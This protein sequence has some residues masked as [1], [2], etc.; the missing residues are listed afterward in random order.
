MSVV[1]A[2]AEGFR[3]RMVWL[4][5]FL[6]FRGIL[7]SGFFQSSVLFPCFPTFLYCPTF[8]RA[9][10]RFCFCWAIFENFLK[11]FR[12]YL[13]FALIS[14]SS[15]SR[16]FS[17]SPVLNH[18]GFTFPRI[19]FML[20][21]LVTNFAPATLPF[22]WL[23]LIFFRDFFL[24]HPSGW[25][26]PQTSPCRRLTSPRPPWAGRSLTSPRQRKSSRPPDPPSPPL[27]PVT[28]RL[29]CFHTQVG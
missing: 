28:A 16:S 29:V 25:H 10:W 21:H 9:A 8:W 27:W 23:T 3:A 2:T 5:D 22:S 1:A 11:L 18:F 20:S 7:L 24:D 13:G 19:R 4:I 17:F 6:S 15:D 14:L 12:A 26:P